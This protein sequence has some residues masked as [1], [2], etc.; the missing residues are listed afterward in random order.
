VQ[1]STR[2]S[3]DNDSLNVLAV[4]IFA[5]HCSCSFCYTHKHEGCNAVQ[6]P[7]ISSF[8]EEALC[9]GP[10]YMINMYAFGRPRL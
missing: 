6:Q 9:P 7:G 2:Q 1:V 3:T 4:S 10:P 8:T 5:P